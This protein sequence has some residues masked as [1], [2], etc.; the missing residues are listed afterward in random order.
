MTDALE[1]LPCPFCGGEAE[2]RERMDENIWDHSTVKWV[3]I[4]CSE[5]DCEIHGFDWP[6]DAEP[7]AADLWNTRANQ[8]AL[9]AAEARGYARAVEDAVRKVGFLRD[10]D[11][12]AVWITAVDE[13]TEVIR[14][15]SPTPADPVAE[16][17]RVLLAE[18]KRRWPAVERYKDDLF[19][20]IIDFENFEGTLQDLAQK[21]GE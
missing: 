20:S 12:D 19:S 2:V 15:L 1:L 3:S 11:D 4:G 7:N 21:E 17:A 6:E 5:I 18:C 16:A 9:E 8:Q 10:Q 14:A 13:A